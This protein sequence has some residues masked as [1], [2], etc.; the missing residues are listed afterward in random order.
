MDRC[1]AGQ[2]VRTIAG[3]APLTTRGRERLPERRPVQYVLSAPNVARGVGGVRNRF[4]MESCVAG[5]TSYVIWITFSQYDSSDLQK[6]ISGLD[7]V[8]GRA[9]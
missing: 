8:P 1:G 4:G 7:F 5:D 2:Q 6:V 3:R 9:T